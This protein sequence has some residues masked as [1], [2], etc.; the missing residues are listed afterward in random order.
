[1]RT[2]DRYQTSET[3]GDHVYWILR[4]GSRSPFLLWW[5]VLQQLH[6][7]GCSSLPP[8]AGDDRTEVDPLGLQ[9]GLAMV[10]PGEVSVS[11]V[12]VDQVVPPS[13]NHDRICSVALLLCP[14]LATKRSF[15]ASASCQ[16]CPG[17][18]RVPELVPGVV[19][20]LE[21]WCVY[22][23]TPTDRWHIAL[24]RLVHTVLQSSKQPVLMVLL[25]LW[26]SSSVADA[27]STSRVFIALGVAL[28]A[29][30]RP[31]ISA[32]C[33]CS[34]GPALPSIKRDKGSA[35]FCVPGICTT[36]KS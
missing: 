13:D 15:W 22:R 26:S 17:V 21:E 12:Q 29:T 3:R 27:S 4:P 20:W 14:C 23:V 7:S 24:Q 18:L 6:N 2:A 34:G 1:M 9:P 5:F 8:Q 36:W 28:S 16:Q 30:K 31:Y 35:M 10:R 19:V 11:M 25:T 32:S 33:L